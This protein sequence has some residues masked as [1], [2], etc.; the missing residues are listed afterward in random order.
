MVSQADDLATVALAFTRAAAEIVPD[1]TPPSVAFEPPR[2]PAFGDYATNVALQLAKRARRPPQQL[3][4]EI[5]AR[6]YTLEPRLPGLLDEATAAAGFINV[7]L[8]PA[9]WQRGVHT[10]LAQ[11][12]AF[13]RALTPSGEH[14]S[15]E[16]GSAN[17]TGPLV[18]VQG[19]TLS[20][21]DSIAKAMRFCGI[22]VTTEWV[23]NDAG[24]QLDTLGRSLYA[25]YRQIA[26]PAFPFPQ[27]GYPG[28]YLLPLADAARARFAGAYDTLPESD[29]LPAFA[30][31]GRDA[32]V[33][34]QQATCERFGV[35]FDRWQSE[36]ELHSSGAVEAGIVA[37]RERGLIEERDGALWMRAT[38]FG[39]DKDRVVVRSD[40]R[41][42][43]YGGDVA[44]HYDKLERND[45]AILIIGPDHHGYIAR[46]K[47]IP[48]AFG[49]PG[50]IDVLIAQQITTIRNGEVVSSSKRHGDV[51]PLDDV[52]DEVGVDAARFFFVMMSAD[53]PMTFDLTLAKEQSNDN[54]VYYVQYG[55]ARIAS[56]ERNAPPALRQAAARATTLERLVA[57]EELALARRLAEFPGVVR[58][59]AMGLA[60]HRLARY[61]QTVAADFTQFYGA[62]KVLGDDFD[63]SAAR[64][65]LSLATKTVLSS[66]LGLLGVRAPDRM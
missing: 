35:R 20:L 12:E 46:I 7:R 66:S 62:C 1:G 4:M 55:H 14:V 5:V 31:F 11:G 60:P 39:D 33:R 61:A 27:D 34:E 18:V 13:G 44:Y 54:P 49:K 32:L 29:W 48:A 28:S 52:L 45:R 43:Y 8:A 30:Q 59:V 19:R 2:N 42:T 24:S 26:D 56:I 63:V 57:P 51:L 41:P 47:L 21:G 16:F 23:I 6:A 38:L 65:S 9:Y 50:A 3:A 58:S 40:G 37:L 17:P 36:K 10:I 53:S 64:L 22:D 25:R 15:L